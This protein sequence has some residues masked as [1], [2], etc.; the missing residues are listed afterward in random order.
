M[1]MVID[2]ADD[3]CCLDRSWWWMIVL[4]DDDDDW[5]WGWSR[6]LI[7][8]D[9][10]DRS[11][12]WSMIMPIEQADDQASWYSIKVPIC[13]PYVHH[14]VMRI[15]L[16]IWGLWDLRAAN[17]AITVRTVNSSR[18]THSVVVSYKP[19]MLVTGA[20]PSCVHSYFHCWHEMM[21]SLQVKRRLKQLWYRSVSIKTLMLRISA[22]QSTTMDSER[23]RW[24]S[25]C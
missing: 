24:S 5:R 11:H 22:S 9:A 2:D 15:E 4:L 13:K 12:C 16:T 25:C 21:V 10:D 7:I 1:V 14:A 23:N 17:C 19:P 3:R 20:P 8:D 6:R 18:S